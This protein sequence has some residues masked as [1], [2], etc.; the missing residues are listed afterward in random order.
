MKLE[1]SRKFFEEVLKYQISYISSWSQI[2]PSGETIWQT[3]W[4]PDK[5]NLTVDF[6]NYANEPENDNV[7]V[8]VC[9]YVCIMYVCTHVYIYIAK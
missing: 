6:R 9:M 4:Q 1:F 3:D 5:T 7:C 2:V 8:Y